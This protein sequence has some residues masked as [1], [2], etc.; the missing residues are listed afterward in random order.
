MAVSHVGD[1][2]NCDCAELL[3]FGRHERWLLLLRS[4]IFSLPADESASLAPWGCAESCQ[5]IPRR[6]VLF[7]QRL[8]LRHGA[9]GR[10]SVWTRVNC[11]TNEQGQR[12][13]AQVGSPRDKQQFSPETSHAGPREEDAREEIAMRGGN[14]QQ[15]R[16][17]IAQDTSNRNP[18]DVLARGLPGQ[19]VGKRR[20]PRRCQV[21]Q[22]PAGCEPESASE[23]VSSPRAAS[24]H[25]PV[26][27]WLKDEQHPDGRRSAVTRRDSA[28]PRWPNHRP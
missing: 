22:D 14:G 17:G 1:H 13:T 23:S 21:V 9:S 16:Q 15:L 20:S 18:T 5:G 10:P 11:S 6:W 2:C 8:V 7:E 28:P 26:L 4:E 24:G 27:H 12:Y 25:G 3:I 19:G